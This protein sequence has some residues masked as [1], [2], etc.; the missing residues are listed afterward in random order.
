MALGPGSFIQL[1]VRGYI[2]GAKPYENVFYYNCLGGAWIMTPNAE[3]VAEA[4]WNHVKVAFRALYPTVM[5][6]AFEEIMVTE[7]NN[8]DGVRGTWAIP[9]AEQAGT[10]VSS[11]ELMPALNSLSMRFGVDQRTTRPGQKRFSCLTELD[12]NAGLLAAPVVAAANALG[13]VLSTDMVLGAPIATG[14]LDPVVVRLGND[15]TVEAWQPILSYFVNEWV[16]TQR[17]RKQY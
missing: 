7:L 5:A 11:G 9:N 6:I 17:S 3:Q 4:W 14:L 15:Y 13:A 8:P 10:R 1:I 12:Q 2:A 16:T